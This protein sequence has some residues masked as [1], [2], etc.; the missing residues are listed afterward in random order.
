MPCSHVILAHQ[1][2]PGKL[3]FVNLEKHGERMS[4][5]INKEIKFIDDIYRKKAIKHINDI[6]DGEII[7]L[8]N[9]RFDNEEIKLSKFI[10]DNFDLQ[11]KSKMVKETLH[12][13]L[14][15]YK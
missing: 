11:R 13:K 5:L 3:D 14:L 9:V 10:N 15:F 2:R 8:D 7:L 4:E 12:H 1:S 6:K